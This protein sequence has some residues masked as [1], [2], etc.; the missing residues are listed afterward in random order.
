MG[1]SW[2]PRC[3][4][5]LV[6]PGPYS[7]AWRCASHGQVL[8]LNSYHRLDRAVIDHVVEQT[9]VPLWFPDPVPLGWEPAGLAVAGDARSRIRATAT[10]FRGP[11]PLGGQGE[12]LII[13]EEPGVGLGA[14]YAGT[15]ETTSPT[16]DGDSPPAKIHAHA[17][18]TSLWA[19]PD[20]SPD[21]SAY[22]GE[23]G[24]VWL[25]LVSF[26]ADAGYAVL[27]NL[28]LI[29]VRSREYTP[30]TMGEASERLRPTSR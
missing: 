10:A 14:A 6:A 17:H 28:S 24:G 29:D 4:S 27:E 13:A 5:E 20:S 26:P 21:R 12:W 16:A 23:A 11:A 22:V 3:G 25:W 2:C 1:T 8:P 9:E 18:P 19:V 15:P 30:P 7:S